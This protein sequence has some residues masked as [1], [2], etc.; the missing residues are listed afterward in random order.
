MSGGGLRRE[1]RMTAATRRRPAFSR[2]E[3]LVVLAIIGGLVGL[4]IPAV[5]KVR[6]AAERTQS[7]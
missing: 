2:V 6:L 5:Q 1:C 3:L 4:L 7:V